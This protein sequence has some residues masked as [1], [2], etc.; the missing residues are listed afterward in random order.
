MDE[1]YVTPTRWAKADTLIFERFEDYQKLNPSSGRTHVV[2]Y[3]RNHG[4]FQR[5]RDGQYIV[6]TS[7]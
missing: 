5:G 1:E 4:L 6:E 7:R 3:L 2:W